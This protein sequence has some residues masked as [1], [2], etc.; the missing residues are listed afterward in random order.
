MAATGTKLEHDYVSG[1]LD[2][3][4][5]MRVSDPKGN[6]FD[7]ILMPDNKIA[8]QELKLKLEY[9]TTHSFDSWEGA[10]DNLPKEY[11]IEKHIVAKIIAEKGNPYL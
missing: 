4:D 3:G 1:G 8:I 11:S 2:Y 6:L 5:R 10:M 7:V 9:G